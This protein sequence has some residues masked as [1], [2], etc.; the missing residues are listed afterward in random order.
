M[1]ESSTP[2]SGQPTAESTP[3]QPTPEPSSA[4]TSD[5]QPQ[6]AADPPA[7]PDSSG[8]VA[9]TNSGVD[10]AAEV[11]ATE[12]PQA[13]SA[14][15]EPAAPADAET[16][17]ANR[18]RQSRILAKE[19]SVGDEVSTA[20]GELLDAGH[21]AAFIG[22]FRR[23]RT[24]AMHEAVVRRFAERRDELIE[25]DRRRAKVV[26]QL[27]S[28]EMPARELVD[29]ALRTGHRAELEELLL[30]LRNPEPE[31][32]IGL[33]RGLGDLAARL[34]A[35]VERPEGAPEVGSSFGEPAPEP[36]RAKKGRGRGPKNSEPRSGE[37]G[38]AQ[39]EGG[40]SPGEAAAADATAA[41]SAAA[42]PTPE[43][44]TGAEPAPAS[45]DVSDQ[46]VT[47]A[48]VTQAPVDSPAESE[49]P[50]AEASGSD[51][52][53]APDASDQVVVHEL[54]PVAPVAAPAPVVSSAPAP[55]A[56]PE[57]AIEKPIELDGELAKVCA[58]F[59]KPDREVHT[60]M[61][62]LE[63]AMRIL[64]DRL[65]RDPKV[66]R[67]VRD[68]LR[69]RGVLHV[70]PG[71]N[72]ARSGRFKALFSKEHPVRNLQGQKLISIRQGLKERAVSVA[73]RVDP[74]HVL[75][76]V[77][78]LLASSNDPMSDGVLDE[79][80]RRALDR[81]LLPMI[82]EDVRL[83]VKERA[84]DEAKR[85]L[86]SHLRHLLLAPMLGPRRAAGLDVDAK[87]DW[88]V[89]TAD[90]GGALLGSERK[91]ELE[92]KD[93]HAIAGELVEALGEHN[94]QWIALPAAKSAR[95]VLLRLRE[96][97]ALA[98]A[99]VT[100][101]VVSDVG[102]SAYANGEAGR[103]ELPDLS[104][105][106]RTALSLA[107]RLQ[108][109]MAELLKLDP[110]HWGLGFE[111]S[112]LTKAAG[113]RVLNETLE[114]C[115]TAI[116]VDFRFASAA[117]LARLPGIDAA[118][119]PKLIAVRD[120]GA[121]ES[122]AQLATIGLLDEA[123]YRECAAFVRFS[124]SPEPLDR[125]ALHPEQYDLAR[126][127]VEATGRPFD[128]VYGR[129]GAG[130]GLDRKAFD[131]DEF[132]WRDL[133]RELTFPGRDLRS[134]L[135]PPKL[136][137]PGTD[138]E[139]LDKDA[140]LEGIVTGVTNFG[141]F[142]DL[143]LE[144]EASLHVS[145]ISDRFLRD[146]REQLHVGQVVRVKLS[147]AKGPRLAV[148]ARGVPARERFKSGERRGGGGGRGPRGGRGD[149][150]DRGEWTKPQK[151]ARVASHR[152]DGMPGRSDDGRGG[153]GGRR[154][155]G[156]G[157]GFSGGGGRR[158]GPGGGRRERFDGGG[159]GKVPKSEV[160]TSGYNNPLKNFFTKEEKPAASESPESKE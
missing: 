141:A 4:A 91:I 146:A 33:D 139:S 124:N 66:R 57:K 123:S 110:R 131:L 127:I 45:A 40:A 55:A 52:G 77:R 74:A 145:A 20:L 81:R 113:R 5:A 78:K 15:P 64:S 2:D 32:Q 118:T 92:G 51:A 79:V 89:M 116:G 90:E 21:S 54:Q 129:P 30:P 6:A 29:S 136:L 42:E 83:E 104:V 14:E 9:P 126:Q 39:A 35:R 60:E 158:G 140:V 34:T 16:Q 119:A 87:G 73:V 3:I 17:A 76:K 63:G 97:L 94:V 100:A 80:A 10:P 148:T 67:A 144:K 49:A 59:V 99:P 135:H 125:S 82:E 152:R 88:F 69:K 117:D 157:G 75:P 108:D 1:N 7:E 26:S 44:A 156:G 101:T 85:L 149:R 134:R 62:A 41:S 43:S 70:Y 37:G 50:A 102:L 150:G 128:E 68:I 56:A 95:S 31:V 25:L 120:Q 86:V 18:A 106:A 137:A 38:P 130:R 46:V 28:T 27:R 11:A 61:Q 47:E 115:V 133:L 159:G 103:S 96:A 151:N 84:E 8:P 111:Q 58:E 12:T 153:G 155:G 13:E 36:K 121:I 138:L 24:G 142:V 71:T 93:T 114:S 143:G 53:S 154:G 72:E 65:G 19:F 22:R 109:P 107:R 112:M 48:A 23:G 122:R 98:G 105:Q 132:T 147:E 160:P